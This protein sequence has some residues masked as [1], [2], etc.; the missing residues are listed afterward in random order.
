MRY[1]SAT[2]A[3]RRS[4]NGGMGWKILAGRRGRTGRAVRSLRSGSSW[5]SC[6]GRSAGGLLR[7]GACRNDFQECGNAAEV[8][9]GIHV[10][11][12]AMTAFQLD[13]G[14]GLPRRGE[15]PA[16]MCQRDHLVPARMQE[17]LGNCNARHLVD[18]AEAVPCHPANRYKRIELLPPVNR[19]CESALHD[20]ARHG[21]AAHQVYC[22]GRSERMSEDDD[23]VGWDATLLAQVAIR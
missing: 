21:G 13:E 15:E 16:A 23:P 18:G 10:E 6:D 3:R 11:R 20:Q 19:G 14:L 12:V 22:D 5:Q 9:G 1:R 7:R 8:S 2:A 17:E 4:G